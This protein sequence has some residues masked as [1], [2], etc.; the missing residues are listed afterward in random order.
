MGYETANNWRSNRGAQI[1]VA[2]TG[3]RGG[4]GV[5]FAVALELDR[6]RA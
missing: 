6:S 4:G 1:D 3:R 2:G 5:D